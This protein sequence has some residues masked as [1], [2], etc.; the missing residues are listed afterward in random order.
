MNIVFSLSFVGFKRG[1]F[2][3]GKFFW[4][5]FFF[6]FLLMLKFSFLLGLLVLAVCLL[7]VRNAS[8]FL[9]SM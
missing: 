6:C 4:L 1:V 2:K 8:T 9:H 3:T 7:S 5:D